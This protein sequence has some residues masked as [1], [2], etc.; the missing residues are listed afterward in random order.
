MAA[1]DTSKPEPTIDHRP[2]GGRPWDPPQREAELAPGQ[3]ERKSR[4]RRRAP[5]DGP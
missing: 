3:S 2:V 4:R 1:G 5:G